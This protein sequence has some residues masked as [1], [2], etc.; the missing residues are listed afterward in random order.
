MVRRNMRRRWNIE[1]KQTLHAH[2]SSIIPALY[3]Q[4]ISHAETV[5][6]H[7]KLTV[8]LHRMRIDGKPL[9]YAMELVED[10][11]E[12]PFSQM[13]SEIKT[14]IE[15]MGKIH[16]CDMILPVLRTQRREICLFNRGVMKRKERIPIRGLHTLIKAHRSH[17][18][19][20]FTS[21]RST[22]ERWQDQGF[23][24]RLL[25]SMQRTDHS[26]TDKRS[27]RAITYGDLHLASRA[28]C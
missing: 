17:R 9:R 11:Y 2:L 18:D 21:L 5:I 28:G 12:P 23:E 16:D 26:V 14:M 7:P 24:Q 3:D 20:L 10:Y 13:L 1:P 25:V 27:A 4:F 6:R 22:L 19:E 8:K 15:L